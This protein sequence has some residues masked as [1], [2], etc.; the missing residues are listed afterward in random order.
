MCFTAC[1]LL[2]GKALTSAVEQE[3]VQEGEEGRHLM[4]SEVLLNC[5]CKGTSQGNICTI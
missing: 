2:E 4:V 5:K 3:G 1:R